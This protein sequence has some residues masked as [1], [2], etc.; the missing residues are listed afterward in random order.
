MASSK[1]IEFKNVEIVYTDVSDSSVEDTMAI[2]DVN[3]EIIKNKPFKS[4]LSLVNVRKVAVNG[5]LLGKLR[6][7]VNRNNPYVLATAV[8]GLNSFKRVIL[9]TLV[10][11]TGRKIIALETIEE[12]KLWL[13]D[14]YEKQMIEVD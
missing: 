14:Q 12:A 13:H 7:N 5:P 10:A 2:M 8:V 9:D 11:F 1:I 6:A 4:V 3:H